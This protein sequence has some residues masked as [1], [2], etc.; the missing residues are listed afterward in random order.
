MRV[1]RDAGAM[2]MLATAMLRGWN[3]AALVQAFR[4]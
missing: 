3:V 2:A 1:G 4:P